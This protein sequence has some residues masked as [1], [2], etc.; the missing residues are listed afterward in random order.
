MTLLTLF[1]SIGIICAA[2]FPFLPSPGL[3]LCAA[4]ASGGLA[5]VLP[6]KIPQLIWLSAFVLGV[7]YGLMCGHHMLANQ[8]SETLAGQDILVEGRV[9]D[10]PQE[11]SRRQLFGFR[12]SKAQT[13][14]GTLID[15][16]PSKINL[17]SYDSLRVKTGEGWRLLVKL[18]VPRGF[19]NPGGFDFQASLMRRGIGATGYIRASGS[20]QLLHQQ[21]RFSMDVL[22]YQLQQWLIN[23]SRSSEKG[24]LVALL[25][26]DTSLVDKDHWSEMLKT[27]TNHLIAISGLHIGFFAIIGF[28]VGNFIGR[29]AQL[30]WHKCPSLN[31]GYSCALAFALF[32]S[33]IAGMNIPTLR[34]LIMLAVVQWVYLWRR[35]FRGY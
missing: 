31:I 18:K 3:V 6:K 25:V 15:S 11:D 24:I 9:V 29:F 23:T 12:V 22:R 17:S 5:L 1:F 20:N 27:G 21:P 19:A 4:F 16:F 10:L 33:L 35:S 30:L 14:S 8:L 34:T 13:P 32:Y 7:S 2:Y 28:L 26:G